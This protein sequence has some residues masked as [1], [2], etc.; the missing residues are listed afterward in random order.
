[1]IQNKN[2]KLEK[3]MLPENKK[4]IVKNRVKSCFKKHWKKDF[5]TEVYDPV[6]RLCIYKEAWNLREENGSAIPNSKLINLLIKNVGHWDIQHKGA[7][8]P[9]DDNQSLNAITAR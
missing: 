6:K 5:I 8:M 4:K 3:Q 2:K 9:F 7:K 1:V